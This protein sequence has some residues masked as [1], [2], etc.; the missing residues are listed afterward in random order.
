MILAKSMDKQKQSDLVNLITC[1]ELFENIFSYVARHEPKRSDLKWISNFSLVSKMF[2]NCITTYFLTRI[3]FTSLQRGKNLPAFKIGKILLEK[4]GILAK[5]VREKEVHIR[6]QHVCDFMFQILSLKKLGMQMKSFPIKQVLIGDM[7]DV[8]PLNYYAF[9][10]LCARLKILCVLASFQKSSPFLVHWHEIIFQTY[11]QLLNVRQTI[12]QQTTSYEKIKVLCNSEFWKLDY[13]SFISSLD[14]LTVT[15]TL[16]NPIYEHYWKLH[17]NLTNLLDEKDGNIDDNSYFELFL[18]TDKNSFLVPAFQPSSLLQT[19]PNLSIISGTGEMTD[20]FSFSYFLWTYY[21]TRLDLHTNM[22]SVWSMSQ[23]GKICLDRLLCAFVVQFLHSWRLSAL[24]T[25][26]SLT[27]FLMESSS[28]INNNPTSRVAHFLVVREIRILVRLCMRLIMALPELG[29]RLKRH[30]SQQMFHRVWNCS[31]VSDHLF[32]FNDSSGTFSDREIVD[33]IPRTNVL[34]DEDVVLSLYPWSESPFGKIVKC[35]LTKEKYPYTQP[36]DQTKTIG[37]C[38]VELKLKLNSILNAIYLLEKSLLLPSQNLK[39]VLSIENVV[40][41]TEIVETTKIVQFT[42]D[43]EKLQ[44]T[45]GYFFHKKNSC[46]ATWCKEF[47][48]LNFSST[49]K[50]TETTQVSIQEKDNRNKRSKMQTPSENELVEKKSSTTCSVQKQEEEEIQEEQKD[51]QSSTAPTSKNQKE[52]HDA[53]MELSSEMLRKIEISQENFTK[54]ICNA[55]ALQT[56]HL[57]EIP[58]FIANQ[59]RENPHF[60]S[61]RL[62]CSVPMNPIPLDMFESNVK[63]RVCQL[64]LDFIREMLIDGDL[65][66]LI[67]MVGTSTHFTN[68]DQ[69]TFSLSKISS[70]KLNFNNVEDKNKQTLLGQSISSICTTCLHLNSRM[71]MKS[72]KD[73]AVDLF[74]HLKK[75]ECNYTLFIQWTFQKAMKLF[76]FTKKSKAKNTLVLRYFSLITK[77]LGYEARKHSVIPSVASLMWFLKFYSWFSWN[78]QVDNADSSTKSNNTKKRKHSHQESGFVDESCKE[79]LDVMYGVADIV[80]LSQDENSSWTKKVKRKKRKKENSSM[81]LNVKEFFHSTLRHPITEKSRMFW[82]YF[83][84]HVLSLD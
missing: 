40:V 46:L 9:S 19:W 81:V 32:Q 17:S 52:I 70:P 83:P 24:L 14:Y 62:R 11:I 39:L 7:E 69:M 36:F 8:S 20:L 68:L 42:T 50:I 5:C 76:E 56:V 48:S 75:A 53:T 61:F 33:E 30:D 71:K 1:P 35:I 45:T 54:W 60:V 2:R 18:S 74:N 47:S 63:S 73:F 27:S 4:F 25:H 55:Q 16:W 67:C 84:N 49:S 26:E 77:T 21:K 34:L 58:M 79:K 72:D 28:K 12:C 38:E 23:I 44:L 78:F 37:T 15:S 13:M 64:I 41:A 57:S 43:F 66:R 65:H 80:G 29:I 59:T 22:T 51:D 6:K 10:F 3:S 82:Y 31:F